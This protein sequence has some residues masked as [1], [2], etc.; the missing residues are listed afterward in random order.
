[1]GAYVEPAAPKVELIG[2]RSSS[3]TLESGTTTL[4]AKLIVDG[5]ERMVTGEGNGPIDAFVHALSTAGL[6]DGKI[7]D[8][9]E[10]TM[11]TGSDATAVAY[12]EVDTGARDT[13]WG[14][15]MHESIV[16]ASLRAIVSAVNT[17][18]G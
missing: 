9:S 8:Y 3:D 14:V 1:M 2:H 18:H 5:A 12:V 16:S 4:E 6:F 13:T 7:A 10:H 11:G 15:G 17:L